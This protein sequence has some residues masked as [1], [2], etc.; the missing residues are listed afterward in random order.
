M[1]KAENM[2]W[3]DSRQLLDPSLDVKERTVFPLHRKAEGEEEGLSRLLVLVFNSRPFREAELEITRIQRQSNIG[4]ILREAVLF[5]ILLGI[6]VQNC[7]LYF[8]SFTT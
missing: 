4:S 3:W 8:F 2:G 6:S 5:M 1:A 7:G